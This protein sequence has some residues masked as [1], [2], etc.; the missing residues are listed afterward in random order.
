MDTSAH[1]ARDDG[2]A[3]QRH[4]D[5]PTVV[6]E[7][8][9]FDVYPMPVWTSIAA[10]DVQRTVDF[11]VG[12]LGF[13]VMFTGPEI[14]GTP[15]LVHVRGRR[16][17]DILVAPAGAPDEGPPTDPSRRGPQICFAS[18]DVDALA[19]RART[20]GAVV[21]GPTDRPWGARELVA[22]DPDGHRLLFSAFVGGHPTG[23]IDDTMQQ[24]V[25]E[26]GQ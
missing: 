10:S 14:A 5:E 11:L 1:T 7:Y 21:D 15:S 3:P 20:A 6:G 25:E 17:Q 22:V 24:V 26:M 8:G 2:A 23:S 19:E 9:G 16:Y 4:A 12:A 13:A 18:D